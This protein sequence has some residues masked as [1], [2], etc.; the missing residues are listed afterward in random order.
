[1][2]HT[3]RAYAKINLGLLVTG[4]RPDGF[5]EIVT[6]F[7]RVDLCDE[8][9]L[10]SAPVI[11]VRSTN[12]HV[13]DG[14]DNICHRAAVLLRDEFRVDAG[15]DCMIV[16]KI[17]VGAGLG[18]GSAD[19]AAVL[20]TVPALW[21]ISPD[22]ATLRSIAVRLGSDVPYFLGDGS[23]MATGRGEI[24]DYFR[25]VVPYAILLCSP[26]IH[27]ATSWAYAQIRP[28]GRRAPDLRSI[29]KRGMSDPSVLRSELIND[30]EDPVII[31]HPVIGHLKQDMLRQGAV[32][33]SMSGSGSCVF[34]FFDGVVA[35]EEASEV[36]RA[37]GFRTFLTPAF[38]GS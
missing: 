17:P 21:G 5:H 7:H 20:R 36:F 24:L 18:G 29:L 25:L 23:A 11:T 27:V 9:T 16:K 34:G 15:M 38:F 37:Q 22:E 26:G 35:A 14:E 12:P 3:V 4:K 31:A 8:I 30:F 10:R 13:P 28:R 32:F 19:G 2:T 1:M 33:A 6:V